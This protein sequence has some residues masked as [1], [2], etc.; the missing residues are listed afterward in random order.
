MVL[1][2]DPD[3]LLSFAQIGL[4]ERVVQLLDRPRGL[5]LVTGPTG[6]GKTTTLATMV[7]NINDNQ[8]C[9]IITIEDPIEY[10][11]EHKKSIVTQREVGTDVPTFGEAIRRA[12]REDPDVILLGEMRDLETIR[13]ALTAAETGHLV[14][15]T[16]HTTGSAR[17]VD[18]IIDAFP[19]KQQEQVRA[20]LSVAIVAVIS[21]ALMPRADGKGRGRGLRGH[22]HDAR[23][24]E[25]HPQEG[26][27]QDPEDDPDQPQPRHVPARRRTSSSCSHAGRSIDARTLLGHCQRSRAI[28]E[29]ARPRRR[30]R[31]GG[32]RIRRVADTWG[33]TATTARHEEA[34]R[35]GAD[36]QG[37][38]GF[39]RRGH[40]PGGPLRPEARGRAA[41]PDPRQARLHPRGPTSSRPRRSR[42]AWSRS[43]STKVVFK[44]ELIESMVDGQHGADLRR[45]AGPQGARPPDR[46]HRQ[47]AALDGARRPAV[48]D[49]RRGGGGAGARGPGRPR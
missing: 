37:E 4:P 47:P 7:N 5:V 33:L 2:S 19:T 48:P 39:V 8:D 42:R 38:M 11:H 10:F 35:A 26:D 3:K 31:R 36:P 17:T 14:F 15:G 13:L 29:K 25:P 32:G 24:R 34:W 28:R 45:G 1:R 21:Q 44:P 22:D 16:L 6:S 27:V 46:R 12:L 49:R 30:G 40:G 9:H 20:Q 23:D 43:T 41:R 18:R